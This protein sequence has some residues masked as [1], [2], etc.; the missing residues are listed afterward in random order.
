LFGWAMIVARVLQDLIGLVGKL[1]A[2]SKPRTAML[3]TLATAAAGVALAVF[4]H[5][6]N[7]RLDQTRVLLG[8]GQKSLHVIQALRSL[9]LQPTPGSAILLKPETRFYQNPWYPKFVAS[10][11]WNDRSL[12]VYVA[13]QQQLTQEEIANMDYVISFNEF[14][15]QLV[16]SRSPIALEISRRTPAQQ[17]DHPGLGATAED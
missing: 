15:A 9:N 6:Q 7:Q 4:T 17:R 13:G 3:R 8:S 2:L 1:L 5:W 11:V 10:L 14:S 12:H 16:R